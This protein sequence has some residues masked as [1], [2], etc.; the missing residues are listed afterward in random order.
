MIRTMRIVL[1]ATLLV[2][3]G[4]SGS[5]GADTS[6]DPADTTGPT[7]S[8]VVSES[9]PVA[10]TA[11]GA[12][13]LGTSGNVGNGWHLT[14]DAVDTDAASTA[15]FIGEPPAPGESFVLFE[16]T[17]DYKGQDESGSPPGLVEMQLVGS[18]GAR[19][20][21]WCNISMDRQLNYQTLLQNGESISGQ[22][23][24]RFPTEQLDSMVLVA[25]AT[26]PPERGEKTFALG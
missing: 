4:C 22:V 15:Q 16:V 21:E 3:G 8:E 5:T 11:T 7:T 17:L 20:D 6:T 26:W 13:P 9:S 18:D 19:H 24:F 1:V 2:A 14:V 10:T 23:C 12:V 25:S